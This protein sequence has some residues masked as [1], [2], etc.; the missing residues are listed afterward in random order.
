MPKNSG[1]YVFLLL[2]AVL[3][4]LMGARPAGAATLDAP[5]SGTGIGTAKVVSDSSGS[6]RAAASTSRARRWS[7]PTSSS[8]R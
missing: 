5:W 3:L 8:R 1:A 7:R 6:S 4:A 2:A